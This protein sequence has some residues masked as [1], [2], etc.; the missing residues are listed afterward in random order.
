MSEV[1]GKELGLVHEAIVTGRKVG[2][3]AQFWS[4]LAH[5]PAIFSKVVD[6]ALARQEYPIYEIEVDY[7]LTFEEMLA[8]GK[9]DLRKCPWQSWDIPSVT[10]STFPMPKDKERRF[11]LGRHR[12][13]CKL[14]VTL[15]HY[16]KATKHEEVETD[17]RERGFRIPKIE[18]ELAFGA[19]FPDFQRRFPIVALGTVGSTTLHDSGLGYVFLHDHKGQ[20]M[21]AGIA[22]G[23]N[24]GE[25]VRFLAVRDPS[26]F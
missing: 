20:R 2:A 4:I 11:S 22:T 23:G 10:A 5:D 15:F 26:I 16:N 3:N 14:E 9:Y 18:E 8:A 17:M 19:K 25:T 12:A 13:V 7:N 6:L 21:I 1:F 24:F